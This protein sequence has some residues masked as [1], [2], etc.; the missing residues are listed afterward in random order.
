MGRW[1]SGWRRLV[2][3][4][5]ARDGGEVKERVVRACCMSSES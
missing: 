3:N 2:T 4:N 1:S 5:T